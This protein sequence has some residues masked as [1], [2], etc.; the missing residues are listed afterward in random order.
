MHCIKGDIQIVGSGPPVP[1]LPTPMWLVNVSVKHWIVLNDGMR[2]R[3]MPDVHYSMCSQPLWNKYN[4]NA[5]NVDW[6]LWYK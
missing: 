3:S 1:S 4:K 5:M 6:W 2:L